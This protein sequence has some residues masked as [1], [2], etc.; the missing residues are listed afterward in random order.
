MGVFDSAF[1]ADLPC[2]PRNVDQVGDGAVGLLHCSPPDLLV[3]SLMATNPR[4]MP[5]PSGDRSPVAPLWHTVVLIVILL[6]L[7]LLQAKSQARLGA[8]DPGSRVLLYCFSILFELFLL[9]YVWILGLRLA[10]KRLGDLIGGRWTRAIDVLRDV[11]V[12]L[13]FWV[14]VAAGLAVLQQVLRDPFMESR[15]AKALFP[16]GIVET[17][18]WVIVSVTAGFC[19]EVV[20]RGYFQKQ[21]FALTGRRDLAV[22]LQ[23][24]IFG[25]AHLYQGVRAV[26]TITLY[27]AMFGILAAVTKSL[28]PGMIQHAAEDAFSGIVGGLLAK[29]R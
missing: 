21:F 16:Q 15:A 17:S 28:R 3:K 29:H 10:G 13:I 6:G 25:V 18:L 19:E 23:A 24:L 7:A 2:L 12:A 5:P 26:I 14:I 8:T 1:P 22:A 20:F 11:G 27:G 9:A 4:T